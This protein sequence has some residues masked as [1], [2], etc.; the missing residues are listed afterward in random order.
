M[1]TPKKA[2][3]PKAD[4]APVKLGKFEG[5]EVLAARMSITATGDGLSDALDIDPQI[6]HHGD[7]VF[8]V[9]KGVVADVQHPIVK[10]TEGVARKHVIRCVDAV[11][12]PEELVGKVLDE[13]RERVRRAAEEA[14]GIDP[15]PLGTGDGKG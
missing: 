7:E 11:P 1:A 9:I 13:H 4:A 8:L 15:L 6:L 10:G 12:V 5:R 2:A 14:A 3:A